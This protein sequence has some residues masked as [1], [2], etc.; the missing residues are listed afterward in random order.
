MILVLLLLLQGKEAPVQ[1]KPKAADDGQ[2]VEIQEP[3]K[4]T[5]D[6][7]CHQ[8]GIEPMVAKMCEQCKQAAAPCMH[9]KFCKECADKKKVCPWCGRVP[10]GSAGDLEGRLQAGI[11]KALPGHRLGR[12]FT[13]HQLPRVTFYLIVHDG[14]PCKSCAK[15]AEA[16]G[17]IE[18]KDDKDTE[19]E[20]RVITSAK[21]LSELLKRQKLEGSEN[22]ALCAAELVQALWESKKGGIDPS[23]PRGIKIQDGKAAFTFKKGEEPRKLTVTLDEK[24]AFQ[25]LS[26]EE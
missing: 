11:D 23:T 5:C 15:H 12:S 19:G 1:Q 21:D 9:A 7:K 3:G 13:K 17:A 10:A 16:L 18:Y 2:A 22:A 8:V 24:G 25:D 26:V 14:T 6:G 20:A 4:K